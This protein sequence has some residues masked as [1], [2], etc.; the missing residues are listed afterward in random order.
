MQSAWLSLAIFLLYA[1][2]SVRGQEPKPD[3]PQY[4]EV[5]PLIGTGGQPSDAGFRTLAQRGYQAVVNLRTAAEK[6]DLIAEEKLV[7]ELG[8]KYYP[9]PVTGNA[10]EES[11]ALEFMRVMDELKAEKVF[12]H[13]ATANRVGSFM[14]IKRTLRDGLSAEQ[15]E[16]EAGRIGLRSDVL[17]QFARDYVSR[18]R[19]R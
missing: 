14:M 15:A 1:I 13:C 5:T 8:L 4:L 18:N 16:E 3:L 9:V 11:Q 2:P 6:V 10:P 12:V 17:R 19:T 7:R